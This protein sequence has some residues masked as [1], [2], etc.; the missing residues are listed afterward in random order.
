VDAVTQCGVGQDAR[1]KQRPLGLV[2]EFHLG[3]HIY[4]VKALLGHGRAVGVKPRTF[5]VHRV[6]PHGFDHSVYRRRCLA[7]EEIDGNGDRNHD[8]SDHRRDDDMAGALGKGL[9]LRGIVESFRRLLM[10][11][12]HIATIL[13]PFMLQAP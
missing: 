8:R 13:A 4:L 10:E 1:Q 7:G 9:S 12:A 6:G 5:H 3:E 2:G 11:E